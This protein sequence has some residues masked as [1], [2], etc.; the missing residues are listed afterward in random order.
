[1]KRGKHAKKLKERKSKNERGGENAMTIRRQLIF[2]AVRKERDR[3]AL[4]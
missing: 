1:V 3:C 2:T 4:S